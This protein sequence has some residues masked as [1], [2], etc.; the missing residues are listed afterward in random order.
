MRSSV[1]RSR[2]SRSVRCPAV[3]S[4]DDP[5]D[6][7]RRTGQSRPTT[8]TRS[9]LGLWGWGRSLHHHT[10]LCAGWASTAT[11]DRSR[12]D[13]PV[14]AGDGFFD[15][16]VEDPGGQPF[17]APA[18]QGGLTGLTEPGCEVP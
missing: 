15:E 3:R 17:G 7:D 16:L 18:A 14:V 12:G 5:A 4:V 10:G 11:S 9:W 2:L 8:S 1:V 13:D 6:R